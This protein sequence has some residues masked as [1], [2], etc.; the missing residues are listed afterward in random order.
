MIIIM[1][2]KLIVLLILIQ[3][4]R[5]QNRQIV[6]SCLCLNT[7]LSFNTKIKLVM[8]LFQ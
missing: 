7:V 3:N 8:A 4:Q 2:C 1:S 5:M 6:L